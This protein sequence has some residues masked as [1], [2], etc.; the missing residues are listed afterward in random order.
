MEDLDRV[1]SRRSIAEEQLRTLESVGVMS[2]EPVA[3]QSER[4]DIYKTYLAELRSR[5]LTYECFCTRKEIQQAASAP[6]GAVPKYPGTCRGLSESERMRRAHERPAAIRLRSPRAELG[7]DGPDDIVLVRNDGVPAYNLAVV[8]DDELQGV[9]QVVRG[10]DLESVTPSQ[11]RLR[12]LLGFRKM[13]HVHLPLMV[14]PDGQRLA[15]RHGDVTLED[16]LRLGFT[17]VEVRSALLRSLEVGSNGWGSSS[18]L[19]EWLR[20]LL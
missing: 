6:H 15:K 7:D 17:P 10:A 2:D 8:I 16:C 5:G 12:D 18:S 19:A 9:S 20:S 13:E 3:Y 1:T 4:F 11:N 14:G